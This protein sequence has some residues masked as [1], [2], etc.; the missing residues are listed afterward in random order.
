MTEAAR[1]IRQ[2]GDYCYT[3][4]PRHPP[5][6]TVKPGERVRIHTVDTYE[7]RITDEQTLASSVVTQPF[8]NPQ[9]GPLFV[10]GA[11][12]G[13]ALRV[14]I[15]DIEPAR[16]FA[17]TTL[18]PS[19]GLL[20]ATDRT[21]LLH[22]PL[23][24]TTKILPLIKDRITFPG[25]VS[26][27]AH[28]FMGSLGVA[29]KL[30][31]IGALVPDLHG[32]NLDCPVTGPGATVEF[33]VNVEGALFFTGDGHAAQSDGEISG[34][35]CEIPAVCTVSFEVIRDR[36]VPVPRVFTDD[37]IMAIGC[38][39]PLEDAARMAARDI[40]RQLE[41]DYGMDRTD[42]YILCGQVLRYRVGNVVDPNYTMAAIFPRTCLPAS[43]GGTV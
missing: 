36:E 33:Q 32:G 21:A 11:G 34:V 41:E 40:V 15:H 14:T 23:P 31:S 10:E 42:A 24:E 6:A 22:D 13:D 19:F 2:P 9:T 39:R 25:G 35:A 7:N 18:V 5:V 43:S 8:V 17:V 38:A 29:P 12:P 37:A 27:P 16:D 3:Y 1:D 20:S 28:Y 26:F 30:E 4:S